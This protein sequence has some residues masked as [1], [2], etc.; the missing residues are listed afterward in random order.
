MST[1]R[2]R[3]LAAAL[4]AGGAF[5]LHQLR[6]L[7]GYGG[8][9]HAALGGQGHA[10][11]TVLAPVIAVALMLVIADLGARLIRASGERPA[12]AP[13]L[14]R[15]WFLATLSLLTAYGL[16]ESL[17]GA[18]APGHPAGADALVG[19][20]GWA[21]VPL[22]VAL[23]LAIALLVRGAHGALEL[24]AEPAV[25]IGRPHA[26]L[27]LT[28]SATRLRPHR[29]STAWRHLARGPPAPSIP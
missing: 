25:R 9:S 28:A 3:P 12:P 2:L 5:V 24:A 1:R 18:L 20:R 27:V 23:A 6:Y 14:G 29:R 15:L 13:A 16:Q 26:A 21:A 22:A 8:D 19:H 10:Y 17:E 11:M 4:L 7:L